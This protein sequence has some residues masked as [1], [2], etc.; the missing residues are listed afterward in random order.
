MLDQ[1]K[2]VTVRTP[3]STYVEYPNFSSIPSTSYD[4]LAWVTDAVDSS[5]YE[6]RV[7]SNEEFY[8][9][10]FLPETTVFDYSYS[11]IELI[12]RRNVLQHLTQSHSLTYPAYDPD[13][14]ARDNPVPTSPSLPTDSQELVVFTDAHRTQF[15]SVSD[16]VKRVY[17]SLE[18]YYSLVS[19]FHQERHQIRIDRKILFELSPALYYV[20]YF[21]GY[22]NL[23]DAE[24]AVNEAK[25]RMST[26][27]KHVRKAKQSKKHPMPNRSNK[28]V[29]QAAAGIVRALKGSRG[30]SAPVSKGRREVTQAPKMHYL[31]NGDC[32]I[33]HKELFSRFFAGA[34]ELN[35]GPTPTNNKGLLVNP[36]NPD[37]FPWLSRVATG[38]ESYKFESLE[39]VYM[40]AC[41]TATVGSVYLAVDYDVS[42]ELPTTTLDICAY[43][44]TATTSLWDTCV[45]A[46]LK[47]DLSKRQ[48]YYVSPLSSLG[49]NPIMADNL[50]HTGRLIPASSDAGAS[51]TGKLT[52]SYRVRLMTPHVNR[53][54]SPYL[55][56]DASSGLS[57]ANLLGTGSPLVM[58]LS[59]ISPFFSLDTTN[60]RLTILRS[61]RY[62]ITAVV[63]GVTLVGAA[64]LV[65]I[66]GTVVLV[67]GSAFVT[68]DSTAANLSSFAQYDAIGGAVVNFRIT[69]AASVTA[70]QCNI[71]LSRWTYG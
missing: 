50:V 32:I 4:S 17:D 35:I 70:S 13:L 27:N 16:W 52:I 15:E 38:W 56:M 63:A 28:E 24:E 37:L 33:E 21:T 55:T 59:S 25:L 69:S 43:R 14:E 49:P 19:L 62:S 6:S 10:S 51:F 67:A 60:G 53:Q 3:T 47:E 34:G 45:F 42:D 31:K 26:N 18:N 66:S 8:G 68:I 29:E 54:M 61:G 44:G 23:F 7:R 71:V 22:T 48:S 65:A 46:A 57:A 36:G 5:T 64:T 58:A 30:V 41:S 11:E 20:I 9:G 39:V 1:N 12:S 40:P 2:R